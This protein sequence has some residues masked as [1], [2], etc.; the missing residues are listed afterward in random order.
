MVVL[1]NVD[2]LVVRARKLTRTVEQIQSKFLCS[3][4]RSN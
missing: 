1:A 3:A 2:H 4:V